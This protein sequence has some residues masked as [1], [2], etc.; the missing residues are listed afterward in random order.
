V[1]NINIT[2][3]WDVETCN[4]IY[5]LLILNFIAVSSIVYTWG[6]GCTTTL[7]TINR[8]TQSDPYNLWSSV[9]NSWLQI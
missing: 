4:L 7:V 1:V 6:R 3:F 2:A 5:R 8:I 9:Q